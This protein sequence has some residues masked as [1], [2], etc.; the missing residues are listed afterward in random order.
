MITGA[1]MDYVGPKAVGKVSEWA[2]KRLPGL[3]KRVNR[4][5]SKLGYGSPELGLH[6]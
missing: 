5:A 4:G 1:A 2:R 3:E 6:R